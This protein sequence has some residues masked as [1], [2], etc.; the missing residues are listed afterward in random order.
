MSTSQKRDADINRLLRTVLK[1]AHREPAPQG[2]E[3]HTRDHG[4]AA[5]P[6]FETDSLCPDA[7][8]MA[9]FVEGN[10]GA[11]ERLALEAHLADCARCQAALSVLSLDLPE[12]AETAA[13]ETRWFTW[14]TRP[15]LRWL[16]P[17][18]AAATVAVVFFATRPLIAPESEEVLPSGVMQLAQAPPPPAALPAAGVEAVREKSAAVPEKREEAG[19][20]RRVDAAKPLAGQAQVPMASRDVPAGTEPAVRTGLDRKP[21]EPVAD[22]M[23]ARVASEEKRLQPAAPAP[24]APAPSKL[25]N[26]ASELGRGAGVAGTPA[27]LARSLETSPLTASAPGGGVLWRFGPGGRL[28][29]SADGGESWQPQASGAAADLLAGAALSP[30]VCW[31]VGS[32]GTVLLTTDGERWRS[33]PFPLTVDLVAVEASGASAAIVT[34]RD[35]RRFET[36][37]AGRTWSPKQ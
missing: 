18:S 27:T 16:V 5:H 14:V 3:S 29:R 20:A 23:A 28:L 12:E 19:T 36:L 2:L 15:R 30:A 25:V 33:L 34:A 7:G 1:P 11:G 4:G 24:A 6:G 13:P 35:G 22:L 10:L 32:A 26:T 31:I 9:A 21:A 17:I 37:D 8:L